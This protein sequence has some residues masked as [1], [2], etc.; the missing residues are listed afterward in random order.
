MSFDIIIRVAVITIQP[1]NSP[2]T[3]QLANGWKNDDG[4]KKCGRMAYGEQFIKCVEDNT[5]S[6]SDTNTSAVCPSCNS[7]DVATLSL[8]YQAD[9]YGIVQSLKMKRGVI[10]LNESDTVFVL[11]NKNVSYSLIISD[12]KMQ[13]WMANPH[14]I[15]RTYLYLEASAGMVFVYLKVIQNYFLCRNVDCAMHLLKSLIQGG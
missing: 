13:L 6:S 14:A 11:L 3:G 1:L 2:E 5:Y 12:P 9:F 15:P 10:S 8:F 7:S 4:L